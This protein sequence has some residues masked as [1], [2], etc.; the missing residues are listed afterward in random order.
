MWQKIKP[1]LVSIV[2]ALGVGGLSAL[3]TRDNMDIYDDIVRPPLSPP[4]ILFP[5]VWTVLF[6]LMGIGAAI[7]FEN[8]KKEPEKVRNALALYVANLIANVTWSLLF[9][10]NRAFLLSFLWILVLWGIILAM[11]VS[12]GKVSKTAALLQIP[13]LLWVTFAAYLNLAIYL[14]NR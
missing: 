2:I 4:S 10:N 12:F 5:I 9:F 11:I 8:R 7:V 1:Y 14:L 6:I 3:L 13:Y